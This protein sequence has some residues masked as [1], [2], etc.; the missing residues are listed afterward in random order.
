[1]KVCITLKHIS[2]MQYNTL[3]PKPK[4]FLIN[5]S[6]S[7]TSCVFLPAVCMSVSPSISTAFSN[8]ICRTDPPGGR[9][10]SQLAEG[11][12]E[13]HVCGKHVL[14]S[15]AGTAFWVPEMPT[16]SPANAGRATEGR[17]IIYSVFPGCR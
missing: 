6:F 1:M 14:T 8:P 4:F 12:W 2:F 7:H 3:S 11:A 16:L 5:L 13:Q 15:A 10:G 9:L 17:L